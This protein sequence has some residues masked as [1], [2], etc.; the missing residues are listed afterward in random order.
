MLAPNSFL[1]AVPARSVSVSGGQCDKIS[2]LELCQICQKIMQ[3]LKKIFC[4]DNIQ[5]FLELFQNCK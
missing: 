3:D 2:I 5:I 4:I 1:Y